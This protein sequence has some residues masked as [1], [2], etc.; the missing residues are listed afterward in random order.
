VTCVP[1][2]FDPHFRFAAESEQILHLLAVSSI[3]MLTCSISNEFIHTV[4]RQLDDELP[5]GRNHRKNFSVDFESA[6]TEAFATTVND[7]LIACE[8]GHD[9]AKRIPP[10]WMF[11]SS[12]AATTGALAVS[13]SSR[14]HQ[15]PKRRSIEN[16][17]AGAQLTI[18]RCV[19]LAHCDR[20]LAVGRLQDHVVDRAHLTAFLPLS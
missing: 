12:P 1:R 18:L 9:R 14:W 6:G 8:S 19:P 20:T 5:L 3:E 15:R 10:N 11:G 17:A 13:G 16:Y 4:R 7:A 2:K